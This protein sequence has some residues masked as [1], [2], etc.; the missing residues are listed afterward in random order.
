MNGLRVLETGTI[1]YI[2]I[3][4]ILSSVYVL[5]SKNSSP[6][7]QS[8]PVIVPLASSTPKVETSSQISPD[9]K[10][11]LIMRVTSNDDGTFSY[12]FS[13]QE[14]GFPKT[15]VY[16]TTADSKL[17]SV[18]FNAWSP[19]DKYFF[20]YKGGSS[21]ALVFR[22]D[23]EPF[24]EADPFIDLASVFNSK[25]ENIAIKEVTGWADP[26]L[27][28]FNK[29]EGDGKKQSYWLEIPSKAIIPLS[30]NFYD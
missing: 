29:E 18:P 30:T 3:A 10:M 19:H 20:I 24:S 6:V 17:F 12:E 16:K 22:A 1:L 27:I 2:I 9:G 11:N 8:A 21:N 14:T 5:N 15:V 25:F 26:A 4:A 23:G 28:V 7:F 13:T